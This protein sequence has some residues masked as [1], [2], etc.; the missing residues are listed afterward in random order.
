MLGLA[1]SLGAGKSH[2][3]SPTLD[4]IVPDLG[5]VPGNV[6]VI[7]FRA[8][9]IKRNATVAE[10]KAVAAWLETKVKNSEMSSEV[11]RI[12]ITPEMV[13]QA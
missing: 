9:A 5:Y 4:R 10:L 2:D 8:N 3:N 6:A 13:S 12:T 7:S 11:G 1:L